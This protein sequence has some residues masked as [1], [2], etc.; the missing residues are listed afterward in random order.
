MC[1]YWEYE[2]YVDCGELGGYGILVL[3]NDGWYGFWNMCWDLELWFGYWMFS[4]IN[5][6]LGKVCCGLD[7]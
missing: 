1:C 5:G 4:V 7:L 3:D 2:F 6:L